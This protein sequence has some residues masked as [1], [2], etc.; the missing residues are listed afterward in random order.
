MNREDIF[1]LQAFQY[2]R[3]DKFSGDLLLQ[4]QKMMKTAPEHYY[5]TLEK[6]LQFDLL[7]TL[8]FTKALEE[9]R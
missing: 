5:H 3:F 1:I 2:F 4:L 9:L 6:Q 7:V 8:K